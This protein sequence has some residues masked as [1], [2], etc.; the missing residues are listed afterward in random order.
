MKY[1][2]TA[3]IR[4]KKGNILSIGKNSYIKTHPLQ[5]KYALI[6][7]LPHKQYIH[8]E[9][10]AIIKLKDVSKAYSIEVIRLNNKGEGLLAKPCIICQQAIKNTPSEHIIHT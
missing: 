1:I 10:A 7:G 9:L 4:D 6:A 5:K 8:A 2:I 3:I